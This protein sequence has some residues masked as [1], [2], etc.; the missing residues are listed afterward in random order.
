M[1]CGVGKEMGGSAEVCDDS[2]RLSS[3]FNVDVEMSVTI[4]A[5]EVVVD[6]DVVVV[7]EVCC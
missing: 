5:V 4:V 3:V 2:G 7:V 1:L 6:D